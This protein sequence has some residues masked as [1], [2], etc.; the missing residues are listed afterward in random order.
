MNRYGSWWGCEERHN[1]ETSSSAGG[2]LGVVKS[3]IS[4]LT[5]N[6]YG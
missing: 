6:D 2:L 3:P 4:T 1:L 5:T